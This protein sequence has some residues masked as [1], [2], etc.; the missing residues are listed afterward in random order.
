MFMDWTPGGRVSKLPRWL[1]PL[2]LVVRNVR[3][4]PQAWWNEH[5]EWNSLSSR[6]IRKQLTLS[7]QY[8][9]DADIS[10]DV[11]E[12]GTMTG[13][14]AVDL[15][16]ALSRFGTSRSGSKRRLWLFDSF[17]GLPQTTSP[18]DQAAPH[19]RDGVW[20]PGSC[21]GVS[22]EQLG[23]LCRK[24]L[25][26]DRISVLD[27]WFAET[28]PTVPASVQFALM[29]IDSDLYQSAV[30]VL[31][32]CFSRQMVATGATILFDDW[33]CNRADPDLG[34]RRA[35]RE[36]VSKFHVEY[37]DCGQYGWGCRKV[38]VHSYQPNVP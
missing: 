28:L 1:Q 33:D 7:V 25:A 15:A 13:R 4:F 35:W 36:C 22:K 38:I 16:R 3:Y 31:D 19:V 5:R 2:A 30:D 14:T 21:R 17:Q 8:L 10:G 6:E 37:T 26:H 9:H 32:G 34:E 20:C 23:Q 29:H 27:G 18:V 24:H 11:A 12:F